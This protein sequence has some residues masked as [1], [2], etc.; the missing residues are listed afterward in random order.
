MENLI[1]YILLS[2]IGWLILLV[3]YRDFDKLKS[4]VRSE[5]DNDYSNVARHYLLG[6]FLVIF[7][8]LILAL[9]VSTVIKSIF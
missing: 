1:I 4:V 6:S 2:P 3:K 7:A 9:I 8:I 5:Y